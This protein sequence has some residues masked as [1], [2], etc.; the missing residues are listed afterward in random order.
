MHCLIHRFEPQFK[1]F[2][3]H[4]E[5]FIIEQGCILQVVI[6]AKLRAV[7]LKKLQCSYIGIIKAKALA[8]SFIWWPNIDHELNNM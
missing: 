8:R 1:G 6:P 2:Q 7:M 3:N 5:E 4:L